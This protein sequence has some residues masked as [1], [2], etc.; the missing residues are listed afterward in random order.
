MNFT[1]LFYIHGLDAPEF[2]LQP[3]SVRLNSSTETSRNETLKLKCNATGSPFPKVLWLKLPFS[4]TIESDI[5]TNVSEEWEFVITKAVT[6][7]SGKYICKVW[8]H[9]G[10]KYSEPALVFVQG[11][12]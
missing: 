8:N 2:T 11:Q 1:C 12:S 10:Q 7:D 3:I 6:T 5:T 9:L 4:D